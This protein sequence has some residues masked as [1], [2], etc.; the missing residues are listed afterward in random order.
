MRLSVPYFS[1][2]MTQG[3]VQRDEDQ[4]ENEENDKWTQTGDSLTYILRRILFLISRKIQD[5]FS[6]DDYMDEASGLALR[7]IAST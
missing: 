6:M 5:T 2:M 3:D 4:G 1:D 7:G